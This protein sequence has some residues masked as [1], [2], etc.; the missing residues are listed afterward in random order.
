MLL[1]WWAARLAIH[2]MNIF[3]IFIAFFSSIA[4]VMTASVED[5]SGSSDQ[6]SLSWCKSESWIPFYW[7]M[8]ILMIT[9]YDG[10]VNDAENALK[11]CPYDGYIDLT[12]RSEGKTALH[13]ASERG[14]TGLVELLLTKGANPN[15]EDSNSRNYI[16]FCILNF[17]CK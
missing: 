1:D 8:N 6:W 17:E 7:G 3:N 4:G 14:H 16:L 2:T 15:V 9:S 10:K 11:H 13:Y 5:K 12:D